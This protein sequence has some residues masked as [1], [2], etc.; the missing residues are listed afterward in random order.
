MQEKSIPDSPLVDH[1]LLGVENPD[2]T[3]DDR[4]AGHND[5]GAVGAEPGDLPASIQRALP[6]AAEDMDD[7]GRSQDVALHRAVATLALKLGDV[8]QG[9]EGAAASDHQL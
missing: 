4:R 6:Q 3:G 1:D 8:G 2:Q 5:V 7:L 9:G